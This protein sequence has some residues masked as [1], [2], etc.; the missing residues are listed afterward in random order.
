MKNS[1]I[2]STI[3]NEHSLQRV[4]AS[5]ADI[6]YSRIKR[7]MLT[8]LVVFATMS[9]G[10]NTGFANK[11]SN[12]AQQDGPGVG[13]ITYQVNIFPTPQFLTQRAPVL[14]VLLNERGQAIGRPQMFNRNTLVYYFTEKGPITGTREVNLYTNPHLPPIPFNWSPVYLSGKFLNGQTYMFDIYI[15]NGP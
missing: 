11:G 4:S 1:T 10:M 3:K 2:Y 5:R 13:V 14:I 6:H 9:M 15:S 8:A 12:A 7:F